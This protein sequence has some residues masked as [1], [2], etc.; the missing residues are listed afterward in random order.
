MVDESIQP[1]VWGTAVPAQVLDQVEQ[2]LGL[3]LP[4]SWC[5]YVRRDK[6]L[7]EG[8]L[9]SGSYVRLIAPDEAM[10]V[11]TAWGEALDRHPRFYL[12]GGDGS[13]DMYCLDLRDHDPMVQL[14]DI[15]SSGWEDAEP[16]HLSVAQFV[17]AIDEGSFRPYPQG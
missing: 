13:R 10:A 3:R 11:M 17:A 5:R 8:W 9:E 7:R 1:A 6:W 15:T 14:T 2:V 16:L 12:L 4:E